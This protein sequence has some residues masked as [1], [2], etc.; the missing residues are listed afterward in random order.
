MQDPENS[1][2]STEGVSLLYQSCQHS[3]SPYQIWD[4]KTVCLSVWERVFERGVCVCMYMEELNQMV[5]PPLSLPPTPPSPNPTLLTSAQPLN[6]RAPSHGR[7]WKS[8]ASFLCWPSPC[9]SNICFQMRTT[10]RT[11]AGTTL[12][13]STPVMAELVSPHWPPHI[14]NNY[15]MKSFLL[16][17]LSTVQL[18]GEGGEHYSQALVYLVVCFFFIGR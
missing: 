1:I 15:H 3:N 2:S 9:T 18:C 10:S 13:S 14:H 5:I 16:L 6:L 17:F 11:L 8:E 12:L 4:C 7:A